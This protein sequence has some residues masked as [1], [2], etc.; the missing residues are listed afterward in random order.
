M[1]VIHYMFATM[2]KGKNVLDKKRFEIFMK[3]VV[4]YLNKKKGLFIGSYLDGHHIMKHIRNDFTNFIQR[5]DNN[6][7]FYGITLKDGKNMINGDENDYDI[8]WDK[9][10]KMI[11]IKQSIWGWNNEIAEPM[12]FEKNLDIVFQNFNLFSVKKNNNFE[13]YYKKYLKSSNKSLSISE[14]NISFLNNVFMYSVYPSFETQNYKI[15]KK[16]KKK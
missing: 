12:L 14:Q 1:F 13:K 8:F 11:G 16:M 4:N 6:E 2:K 15:L 9:N 5:D 7:P 3:N 10:P